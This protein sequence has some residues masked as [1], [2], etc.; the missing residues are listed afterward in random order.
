MISG[1]KHI[2]G[3]KCLVFKKKRKSHSIQ[4]NR[5]Y[6]TFKGKKKSTK[7]VPEKDLKVDLLDKD[8]KTLILRMLK[9]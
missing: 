3:F 5:K 9:E 2:I 8:F 7:T 6:G 4:R 1:V